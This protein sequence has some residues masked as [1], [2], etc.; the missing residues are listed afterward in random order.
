MAFG[1]RFPSRQ[2]SGTP[3]TEMNMIPLI[4]V[5]LVLLVIFIVTAPLIGQAIK[6]DLPKADS[7][8]GIQVPA[9][10]AVSISADG[11]RHIDG[12]AVSREESRALFAAAA[13]KKPMPEV[14]IYADRHTDYLHPPTSTSAKKPN[15]TSPSRTSVPLSPLAPPTSR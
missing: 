8:A 2:G 9:K 14:H 11:T 4:D 6:I 15:S 12:K 10:M 13:Q 5:M 7:S 1:S 3:M